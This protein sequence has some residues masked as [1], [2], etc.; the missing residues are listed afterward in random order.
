MAAFSGHVDG[1]VNL[2]NDTAADV[3]VAPGV[4]KRIVVTGITG[5]NAHATVG[6]KIEIRSGTTVRYRAYAA[7]GGGGFAPENGSSPIF[8]AADNEA[9]TARCVTTGTD[10]DVNIA[11]YVI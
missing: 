10:V 11:G 1:T 6:T 9:I 4:G 5:T 8:I 2:V 7:A 3:I